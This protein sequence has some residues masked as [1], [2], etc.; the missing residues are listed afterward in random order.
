MNPRL[1]I[2]IMTIILLVSLF[3]PLAA[4]AEA[5]P[6]WQIALKDRGAFLIIG[7]MSKVNDNDNVVD[8][9]EL[10]YSK[11]K[12]SAKQ[13]LLRAPAEVNKTHPQKATAAE[14][15]VVVQVVKGNGENIP[16]TVMVSDGD[17]IF[18]A[19]DDGVNTGETEVLA[20]VRPKE[21]S[22]FMKN[23]AY[24][25]KI[26]ARKVE[27]ASNLLDGSLAIEP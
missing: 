2:K 17:G 15:D 7:K 25:L 24:E 19:T 22:N 9:G 13:L 11:R 1:P 5:T 16:D 26:E 20:R 27:E 8:A 14:F 4:M 3:M 12:M 21:I 23:W 6:L 10:S 18:V